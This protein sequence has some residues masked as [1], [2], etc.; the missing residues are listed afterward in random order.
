MSI[1]IFIDRN[2]AP[3]EREVSAAIGPLQERWKTVVQWTHDTYMTQEDL[4]FMYGRKYGWALRFRIRGDLAAALYPAQGGFTAQLIL[5]RGALEKA[6]Q[7][8]LGKNARD[9]IAKA[10]PYAEGKWLFIPIASNRDVD[11]FK[12]LLALKCESRSKRKKPTDHSPANE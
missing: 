12:H 10:H 5:N 8:P 4:K 9:A 1:G 2:H 7:L 3:T 6:D 11:D